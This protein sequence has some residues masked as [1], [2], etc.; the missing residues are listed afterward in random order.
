MNTIQINGVTI[1]GSGNISVSN[2]KIIVNGV[3]VTPDTKEITI[4]VNG[5]TGKINVDA[6]NQLIV[7][8]KVGDI[9]TMSGDVEVN[10]DV[11]G[12]ISTMSGDVDCGNVGGIVKSMS[13][14][15]K[16]KK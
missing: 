3:D 4:I 12:S 2:G 10:G 5:D 11:T 15:I 14:D 13:G 7:T 1:T 8:G 16:H 9:K 6:C